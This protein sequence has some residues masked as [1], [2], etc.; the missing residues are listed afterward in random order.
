MATTIS[1]MPGGIEFVL[2]FSLTH[3]KVTRN[4]ISLDSKSQCLNLCEEFRKYLLQIKEIISISK[5]PCL[6]QREEEEQVFQ[7]HQLKIYLIGVIQ[8]LLYEMFPPPRNNQPLV[9]IACNQVFPP[10]NAISPLLLAQHDPIPIA[11]LKSLPFYTME[12]YITPVEHILN[13]ASICTLHNLKAENFAVRL[14][15][16]SFKGKSLQWFRGLSVGIIT[17]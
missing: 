10:F 4:S 16:T 5:F 2:L 1:G 3:V 17:T 8:L 12:T 15:A 13:V 9:A 11:T 6:L 14:L 7:H